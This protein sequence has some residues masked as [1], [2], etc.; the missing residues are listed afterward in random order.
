MIH[1]ENAIVCEGTY[2]K[3]RL[4]NLFEAEIIV[5][6]GFG[7][8]RQKDKL[9]MICSLAESAPVALVLDPDAAGFSI[10]TF[11]TDA[12]PP[13]RAVQVYMPDL[14]GKEPRKQHPGKEGKLG[15][16]GIP[17]GMIL[18]AFQKAGLLDEQLNPVCEPVSRA[19]FLSPAR[20]Y[21]D[22]LLGAESSAERRRKICG[23]LDLP[24]RLNSGAFCRMLNRLLT[25]EAYRAILKQIS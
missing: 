20:L 3:I 14:F 2:D 24:A 18:A 16:E 1:L 25:E 4:A 23:L 19:D 12:L 11:L 21:A 5:T 8:R 6:D 13:G 9:A 10:R 22:G 7:I 17:D 15:V